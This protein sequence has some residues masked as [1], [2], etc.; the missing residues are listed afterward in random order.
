MALVRILGQ[1]YGVDR[2]GTTWQG[3]RVVQGRRDRGEGVK[4]EA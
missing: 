1:G 2:R 4:E 3:G